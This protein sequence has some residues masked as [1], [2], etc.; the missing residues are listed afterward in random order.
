MS[1]RK[2][3]RR[4]IIFIPAFICALIG[5]LLF[6]QVGRCRVKTVGVVTCADKDNFEIN[7]VVSAKNLTGTPTLHM[8]ML[9]NKIDYYEGE[10]I[11]VAYNPGNHKNFVI[12]DE[13][14]TTL[15][16]I[17]LGLGMVMFIADTVVGD[18]LPESF[19]FRTLN[20]DIST[21]N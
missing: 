2:A 19:V 9:T 13:N 16:Y 12:A 14:F 1:K 5:L 21:K 20:K 3:K 8:G 6:S 17:L 4:S 18:F 10:V 7:Y 15:S 11:D